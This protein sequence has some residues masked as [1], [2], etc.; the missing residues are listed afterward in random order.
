[1]PHS[2][3]AW[4][5]I[6]AFQSPSFSKDGSRIFHLR[7]SGLPQ[8]WVMDADGGNARA[9]TDFDEKVAII[10]R[11]PDDD[12]L[13]VGIDAGGDERQQ[14]HLVGLDGSITALTEAPDVIHDFGAWSPDG[15]RIA[16]AANDRDERIFDVLIKELATGA[17]TQVLEG[18]GQIKPTGWRGDLLCCIEDRSSSDQGLWVI[19]LATGA[20]RELPAPGPTRYASIRFTPDGAL[21]GLTDHG[22]ADFMR[23]C[24]IDPSNGAVGVVHAPH[25]R[26]VEAWSQATG[27]GHLA[28]V[29]NDRGYGVLR[30]D[31]ALVDGTA[32]GV[33]ADLAWSPDGTTLAFTSQSPVD[34]PAIWLWRD[35]VASKLA[36]PD[37]LAENG[38][39]PSTPVAPHLVEWHG[40]DGRSIPG[41]F[42]L[43]RSPAPAS[44]Y[45]AVIWVHGGPASQT[46]ANFRADTQMLL[47]QGFA[48]LL[49]NVR[50]STGYGRAAMESDDFD[51][52]P[53]ALADLAAGRHWLAAQPGIDPK[54]IGVMGQ[55][56]GGWMVLG[57]IT[58]Y[59]D[60]WTAAVDYYGIADFVTLLD[61]TGP[62]RRDHRAREYGFPDTHA[63]LFADISPI[64][65]IDHVTAPLLVAHGNRDPRVP[66]HESDQFVQALQ[67]RQKKV[68][69]LE[70]DYAGHGFIRPQHRHDIYE[71]VAEHFRTYLGA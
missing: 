47:D 6:G 58:R 18:R 55:S 3:H 71:A 24:R 21:M 14:F 25:D 57:A 67:E 61:R 48:V 7:G 10:R 19:D 33:V 68:R 53:A 70:F 50:G 45:P 16:Y 39:S 69:Y 27:R 9:L 22:G 34:P 2:A 11:A 51:L 60:L 23:L 38:I 13:I 66:K 62:W 1:M 64:H 35:G 65:R 28:V 63:E 42:A 36:G 37:M 49:P 46:R 31:G 4:S 59:P 41:W 5:R 44:G 32:L 52:R 17:V 12:R 54:R 15:S 8:V 56:Y 29:E 43:P 26:D 40:E 30:I 20:A